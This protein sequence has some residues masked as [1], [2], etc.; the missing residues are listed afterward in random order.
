MAQGR[1]LEVSEG[2]SRRRGRD[3]REEDGIVH[4]V[5][6]VV[7]VRKWIHERRKEIVGGGQWQ[8]EM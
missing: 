2:K 8:R 6:G 7:E 4:V 1:E 3:G 5:G